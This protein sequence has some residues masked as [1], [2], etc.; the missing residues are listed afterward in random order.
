MCF[1]V[2]HIKIKTTL[3][4]QKIVMVESDKQKIYPMNNH[5]KNHLL[6]QEISRHK[7]VATFTEYK[8]ATTSCKTQ[9]KCSLSIKKAIFFVDGIIN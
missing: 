7:T 2:C 8:I 6:E 9:P 5:L 1:F 3:L 4:F